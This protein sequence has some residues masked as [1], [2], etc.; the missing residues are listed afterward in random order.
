MF[1]RDKSL[2]AARARLADGSSTRGPCIVADAGKLQQVLWN[3][4]RNAAEAA[5]STVLVHVGEAEG[6][7]ARISVEDDGPGI[8]EEHIARIFE[9]FY[10]TKS[11]GSGLGLATVQ[12]IV[13]AHGGAIRAINRPEGGCAFIVELPADASEI[14]RDD[15]RGA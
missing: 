14:S 13:H 11:R 15:D 12:S 6:G 10:T 2:G 7:G 1:A 9:P 8:A 4:L 3:L 5:D